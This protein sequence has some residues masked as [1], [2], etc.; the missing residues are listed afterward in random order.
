MGLAVPLAAQP[1]A[2]ETGQQVYRANC[3]ACHG[4]EGDSIPGVNFRQAQFRRVSTDAD[5]ARIIENGI[6]GTGMPPTN[7]PEA[8]RRALVA[9]VRSMHPTENNAGT[10]DP[11]RGMAL[12]QGKGGCV[13]C[14]RVG[15]KGS[16]LGPDLSDVGSLRQAA[17]L[18][19]SIVDPNAI[20]L[21]QHRYVRAVTKDGAVITGRRLNEDT[22]TIELIDEH[23][24]L[25]SLSKSD[26]REY[27][28]IKTSPMPSYQ[29]KL[30]PAEISDLVSYLL[31]LKGSN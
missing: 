6:P 12:F 25:V 15:E 21:P 5:L 8:S 30:S 7:M 17:Y 14:H 26:L 22:H 2:L 31:S 24:R 29:G 27:T 16:R 19:K 23:E 3:F 9:Y 18:E 1:S 13:N 4:Q 28:L 20:V 10:G 11:D